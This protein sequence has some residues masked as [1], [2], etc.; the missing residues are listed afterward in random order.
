MIAVGEVAQGSVILVIV[1]VKCFDQVNE[2]MM[3]ATR[4]G[5][6]KAARLVM[7]LAKDIL[8]VMVSVFNQ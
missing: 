6:G 8:S 7:V 2:V 4:E 3:I 5:L 1:L